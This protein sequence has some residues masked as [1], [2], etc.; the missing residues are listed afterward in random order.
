VGCPAISALS[1]TSHVLIVTEATQS[2]LHDLKRIVD[3]ARIFQTEV[4]CVVNKDDLNLEV[5]RDIQSFCDTCRI[6]VLA[7]I[8]FDPIFSDALRDGKTL[9]ETGESQVKRSIEKIW[10]HLQ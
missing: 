8:P 5:R 10:N 3:L 1:G 9:M 6:D 2:G 4:S 7:N